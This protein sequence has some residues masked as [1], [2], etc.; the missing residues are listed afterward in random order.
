MGRGKGTSDIFKPSHVRR[1]AGYA[2]EVSL[3]FSVRVRQSRLLA[4][5]VQLTRS[6]KYV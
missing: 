1:Q 4:V 6:P 2:K 5:G 3:W